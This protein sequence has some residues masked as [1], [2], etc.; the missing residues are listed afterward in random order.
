VV[1]GESIFGPDFNLARH[2]GGDDTARDA[3]FSPDFASQT[4]RISEWGW[5]VVIDFGLERS[6]RR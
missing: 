6:A 1:V 4:I 2:P 5:P 3:H